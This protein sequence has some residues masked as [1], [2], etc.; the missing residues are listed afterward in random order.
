ME[1]TN[2]P[3]QKIDDIYRKCHLPDYVFILYPMHNS[4]TFPMASAHQTMCK[5]ICKKY[6][7]NLELH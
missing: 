2:E 3:N 7:K 6:V 5:I 1:K 4:T